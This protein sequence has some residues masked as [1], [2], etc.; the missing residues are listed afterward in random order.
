M[1]PPLTAEIDAFGIFQA[2]SAWEQFT[3]MCGLNCIIDLDNLS[4]SIFLVF[5]AHNTPMSIEK[6]DPRRSLGAAGETLAIHA[7]QSAGLTVIERNW[8]CAS[9]E[10]DIIAEEVAPDLTNDW[11]NAPWRVFVEV[12]TRRGHAFGTALQSITRAKAVKMRETAAQYV[13]TNDWRGPWRIDVVA[14]QMD[15]RGRLLQIEHIRHA[16]TGN[17]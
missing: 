5:R 10:I 2:A 11:R 6:R 4:Y 15:A 13:Q 7:L 14:V 3:T 1:S 9:G 8:R 12:R 16:V 17:D